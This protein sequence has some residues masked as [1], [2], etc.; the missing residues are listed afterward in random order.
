MNNDL[1]TRQKHDREFGLAELIASQWPEWTATRRKHRPDEPYESVELVGPNGHRI[2][3]SLDWRNP[4]RVE[5]RGVYPQ[6]YEHDDSWGVDNP[7]ITSSIHRNPSVIS[8]DIARRLMPGYLTAFAQ[9]HKR[10]TDRLK[11][12]DNQATTVEALQTAFPALGE[13][14]QGN[15]LGRWPLSLT[16]SY[17]GSS[18]TLELHSVPIEIIHSVLDAYYKEQANA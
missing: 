12:A 16:V 4:E 17:G 3:V 2:D 5:F 8:K 18:G 1:S 6:G 11:A 10:M 15:K 7:K 13:V 9:V 14:Y